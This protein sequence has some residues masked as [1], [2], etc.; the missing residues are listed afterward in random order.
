MLF[1]ILVIYLIETQFFKVGQTGELWITCNQNFKVLFSFEIRLQ[2]KGCCT[3]LHVFIG[4]AV[5]QLLS[6]ERNF[7]NTCNFC[8]FL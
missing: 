6:N 7:C 8:N 4:M 5:F 2:L 3:L 1:I